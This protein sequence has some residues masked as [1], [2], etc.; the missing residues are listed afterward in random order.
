MEVK[1]NFMKLKKIILFSLLIVLCSCNIEPIDGSIISDSNDDPDID[2][3]TS[4]F[5]RVKE[6]IAYFN[7]V[8]VH[9]REGLLDIPLAGEWELGAE[10]GH[11]V[12]GLNQLQG[13]VDE[14]VLYNYALSPEKVAEMFILD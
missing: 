9:R 12:T 4:Q 11:Q 13:S 3:P 5:M 10:I 2:P 6:A 8:E 1:F 14:F 7:G